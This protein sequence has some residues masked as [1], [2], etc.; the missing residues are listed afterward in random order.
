[1]Y[2]P[3]IRLLS[4]A[5]AVLVLAWLGGKYILPLGMPFLLGFL[6]ALG[7]EPGV[8][9]LEQ[10]FHLRRSIAAFLGVTTA[11]VLLSAISMLLISLLVKELG[12]LAGILPDLEGSVRQGLGSLEDWLLGLAMAAPDGVR[13][14]LIRSILSL[15]DS[16]SDL[17]DRAIA[18]L[19]TIATGV[20]SHV[21][22][23]FLTAGTGLLSAYLFSARMPR[24]RAWAGRFIPGFRNSRWL[25][26]LQNL[27]RAVFGWLQAQAKLM[28]LTFAILCAGLLLLRISFAPVWAAIIALVD[29]VPMLGTGLILAPWSLVCFLRGDTIRALGMLG[30][31]AAAT[32]AR[33]AL[34]PR[35]LG[36]QLG[37]DPLVTLA[38]LYLGYQL[39]GIPGLMAS[40]ILAVTAVQL[41]K[42]APK[43]DKL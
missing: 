43:E 9:F 29:A 31:F 42:S 17:Y 25:K 36:K 7:A 37:L 4:A 35:L 30:L 3:H 1:M 39:F 18:Q 21:P 24:I 15:F 16:G 5:L 12:R 32:V 20:L 6:L 27:K 41:I 8:R 28:A 19:P 2:H 40:P 23:S 26:V 34:E 10:R 22:D 13:P 33:S 14:L 38:A 11:L